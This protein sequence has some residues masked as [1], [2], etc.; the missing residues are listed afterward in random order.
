MA[1][2]DL[3][4]TRDLLALKTLQQTNLHG[5]GIALHIREASDK[6]LQ[7]EE[8]SLFPTLRRIEKQGW[9]RS[10]WTLSE[11]NRRAKFDK[12]TAILQGVSAF[13]EFA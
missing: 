3:H 8:G 2:N 6:L 9:I 11:T 12:L 10:E 5:Y 1:K 13:L 7:L 4:G